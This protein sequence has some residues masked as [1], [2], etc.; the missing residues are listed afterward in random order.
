MSLDVAIREFAPTD[1][2]DIIGLVL[3]LQSYESQFVS[4]YAVPDRT[5]GAWYFDRLLEELRQHQGVMIVAAQDRALCGFCAGFEEESPEER[6]RCFYIAELA[7]S[8]AAR[9]RG[10]GTRL[11][12]A[13][14]DIARA[15]GYRTVEV[16]VLAGNT[17]VHKLYRRLGFH[18]HAVKLRKKLQAC[19]DLTP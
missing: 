2:E 14:E 1:R 19:P 18:D 8:E 17:R 9:G 6:S 7:V 12:G 10:V 15:R 13:I 16:G 4:G 3:E 5:F 11:I